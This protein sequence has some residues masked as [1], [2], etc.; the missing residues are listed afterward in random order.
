MSALLGG[1]A[2][3][4][5]ILCIEDDPR[6]RRLLAEELEEAGYDV[7]VADSAPAGLLALFAHVPALVVC[8]VRMPGISG[9]DLLERLRLLDARLF[10]VAF[11][12]LTALAD[13]DNHLRGRR[14]GADDYITKPVDYE[15]LLEIVRVRLSG[16]SP[17]PPRP[18][19]DGSVAARLQDWFEC[20]S[21]APPRDLLDRLRE[22]FALP[23]ADQAADAGSAAP[24]IAFSGSWDAVPLGVM[25]VDTAGTVHYANETAAC[26]LGC[27]RNAM[28]GA[29]AAPKLIDFI[30]R[31]ARSAGRAGGI[32]AARVELRSGDMPMPAIARTMRGVSDGVLARVTI[33]L[34]GLPGAQ[35]AMP[36]I[37][38]GLFDLTPAERLLAT[39]I[40]AGANLADVAKSRGVTLSTVRCQLKSVFGKMGVTRQS[41]LVRA[42]LTLQFATGLSEL[43]SP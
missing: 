27:A 1:A 19:L 33:L 24:G 23:I 35:P 14:L 10:G 6:L 42:L 32:S 43:H 40:G 4:H 17:G 26:L 3:H 11:I 38:Q 36:G 28:P 39:E 25:V 41:D 30:K 22:R 21:P 18:A 34:P 16:R 7:E 37:L 29:R 12:F 15:I 31:H 5:R 9:F 2:P 13:R 8:D 20:R